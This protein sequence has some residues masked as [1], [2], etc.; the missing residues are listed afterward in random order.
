M[1]EMMMTI[2]ILGIVSAV[3]LP[4]FASQAGGKIAAASLLLRDD[5]E[6]ARFRTVANPSDPRALQLDADG[7]G[8]SLVNPLLR[9]VPVAR[10]DGSK[11]HVRLGE[12]RAV[13]LLGVEVTL[14]GVE[15]LL[16]AFDEAGAVSDR[17]A[18]PSVRIACEERAQVLTIG[19]VTGIVHVETVQ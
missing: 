16:L 15:G 19:V 17:S 3:A 9:D 11:W 2:M 5:L 7:R 13:G 18:Q 8:W 12:G 4:M 1:V 10:D 14:H 6:Q